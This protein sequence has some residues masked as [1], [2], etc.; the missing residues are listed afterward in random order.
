M[1]HVIE[2]APTG[3]AKCRGCE[4]AIAAG[5]LR[6]GERR[7]N[8][9]AEDGGETT[10]WFHVPCAALTRPEPFLETI[11][12][13]DADVARRDWFAQ[14]ARIGVEH[15]RAPRARG[16]ARAASGRAACRSCREPIAKGA[17]RIALAYY[18]DGRFA[19]SGFVHVR[20]APAYFETPDVIE[21][22]KHFSPGLTDADVAELARE[23]RN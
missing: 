8:P 9:Y 1:P 18:E 14:E 4:K 19:P 7:P 12:T 13:S 6:F 17:W 5:E 21:R 22:V 20:C 10:H 3:R 23:L 2:R 16:V 15:R 11:D